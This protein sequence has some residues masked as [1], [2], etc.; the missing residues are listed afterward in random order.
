VGAPPGSTIDSSAT[1]TPSIASAVALPRVA[2]PAPPVEVERPYKRYERPRSEGHI[3][4]AG[5]DEKL[6]RWNVGGNGDPNFVSNRKNYH[7]GARV[8]VDT[9]LL[10]GRLA[11]RAKSGM[12]QAGLLAQS[13]SRGY[14]PFRMCYEDALRRDD[15]Q[16]GQTRIRVSIGRSGKVL[17]TRLIES[18]L[19]DEAANCLRQE[20]TRLRYRPGMPHGTV[21]AELSVKFW[22][23]DAPVPVNGPPKD[24]ELNNPTV[25][26]AAAAKQAAEA[27]VVQVQACYQQGLER[28]PALWGRVQLLL[29]L[30][31]GGQVEQL[32]E[33]E[34]RFPDAT[35]T[36]CIISELRQLRVLPAPGAEL[37]YVQAFR[38]GMPPSDG[39]LGKKPGAP[40]G[41]AASGD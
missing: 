19:D 5:E 39:E 24:L 31:A 10:G 35:V 29:T 33:S 22:P 34:S 27:H 17:G 12:S 1:G 28:D 13:R 26:D 3:L 9:K 41:V 20:L 36:Q 2:A 40:T 16:H 8:V 23:G 25:L 4:A 6:A 18:E 15:E 32:G 7:P 14:W 11:R 38:L 37:E 30:N 21:T